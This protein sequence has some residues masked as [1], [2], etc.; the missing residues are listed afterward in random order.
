VRRWEYMTVEFQLEGEYEARD[1]NGNLHKL[2]GPHVSWR[3]GA[4]S[5]NDALRDFGA[6][7]WEMCGVAPSTQNIACHITYF[8]R[9]LPGW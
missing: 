9:E 7:G 5:M 6:N 4:Q 3:T 8:K 2:R 1:F